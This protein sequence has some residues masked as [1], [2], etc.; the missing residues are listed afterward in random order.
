LSIKLA[1]LL[2]IVLLVQGIAMVFGNKVGVWEH[3]L[4]TTKRDL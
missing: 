2:Y 1:L 4:L 3:S